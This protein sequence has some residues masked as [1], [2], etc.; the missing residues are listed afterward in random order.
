MKTKTNLKRSVDKY[1]KL[2]EKIKAEAA[3]L[4]KEKEKPEKK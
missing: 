4:K 1:K 2:R 3:K